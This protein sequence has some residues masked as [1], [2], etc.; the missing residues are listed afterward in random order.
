MSRGHN[1][2]QKARR[3]QARESAEPKPPERSPWRR[4]V[5]VVLLPILVIVAI[6]AIVGVSGFGA[7]GSH[8]ID[9]KQIEREV[10]TDLAGIPQHGRTLGSPQAPI[11]VQVFADLECPTVR[12]FVIKHLPRLIADWV[13]PGL[14]QLQY[15]SLETDTLN[16]HRFFRQEAATLAAGE[17]DKLW[18]FFL[19]FVREQK[20]EY[21]GYATEAFL[22]D[23]GSQIQGLD[24]AQWR[25]DGADPALYE[26]VALD[27]H[28]AH[29]EGLRYT[30]SFL[31]APTHP[32]AKA[33]AALTS[34]DS[35][36]RKVRASVAADVAALRQ[37]STQDNP[38]LHELEL[39]DRKEIR[40]LTGE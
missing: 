5:G 40:E 31:L 19:T 8:R 20:L 3:H 30:P 27:L 25:K 6:F 34:I 18:N 28:A 9:T 1:A 12:R 37:E 21:S 22:S 36:R 32:K 7:G 23:I 10:A 39:S 15:H 24:E 2:R 17:Q 26:R 33:P 13:R 29:D 4:R 16:E 35:L 14:V 38:A 11:T